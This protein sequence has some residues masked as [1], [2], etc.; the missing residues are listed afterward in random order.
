MATKE[1]I[2]PIYTELQGI[3]SQAPVIGKYPDEVSSSISDVEYFHTVLDRLSKILGED[4]SHYR[5]G[6]MNDGQ[7]FRISEYRQKI[8]GLISYLYGAY[9]KDEKEPF[10]GSPHTVVTQNQKQAQ[11]QKQNQVQI[12]NQKRIYYIAIGI[13][14]AISFTVSILFNFL[15]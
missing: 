2:R 11:S 14:V 7:Y 4:L 3:L 12:I 6:T 5:V 13:S 10:S 1:E 8:S 9:F 15:K